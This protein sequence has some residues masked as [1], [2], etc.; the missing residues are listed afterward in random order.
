[1]ECMEVQK[2]LS[3]Y[4]EKVV[5]PKQKALIDGHLKKCKK[6]KESLADLKKAIEYV[7]KLEEVEPPAWLAQ[8][9]MAQVRSEA[10]AKRVIWQRLFRPFHIK[11]PLE[12]I[13]LIF[14][15][16]GAIYIFKAMQPAMRLAKIPTET[17][18][19]AQA[20]VTAF[21]KEKPPIVD[22]EQPAPAKAR[23]E[24]MYEKKVETREERR[25]TAAPQAPAALAKQEGAASPLG[26]ADH[27]QVERDVASSLQ[28]VRPKAAAEMRAN[29]LRF[30]VKVRD[31]EIA[32]RDIEGIVRQLGGRAITSEP[33]ENKAVI[34]AE[35]DAKKVQELFDRLHLIGEVQKKGSPVEAGEGAVEVRVEVER[36]S[37]NP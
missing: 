16:V 2:R 11:I 37:P 3:A 30:V 35:L 21:K 22:K 7:Q 27:A 6:C 5:S 33:Y 26:Y 4:L 13:A 18:E 1:M 34:V 25:S 24:L 8:K 36:I 32:S 19:V 12:A 17:R 28:G 31:L 29:G 15:A 10:E 23:E 9:V 20:P 14:I